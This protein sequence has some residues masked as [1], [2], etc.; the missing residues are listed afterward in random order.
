MV[1]SGFELLTDDVQIDFLLAEV[2]G[3]TAGCKRFGPHPED[4]AIEVERR[5]EVAHR[6]HEMVERIDKDHWSPLDEC[7][8]EFV[9]AFDERVEVNT[10]QVSVAHANLSRDHIEIDI[11]RS[12]KNEC[13]ERVVY[14]A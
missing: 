9:V 11:R 5:I 14:G 10:Q 8:S 12:A 4:V 3:G 13:R 1:G 2:Y 7:A 6:E